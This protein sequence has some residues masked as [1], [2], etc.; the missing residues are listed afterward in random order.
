MN[1]SKLG[2]GSH[3][4]LA[5][6]LLNGPQRYPTDTRQEERLNWKVTKL[7]ELK[8]IVT[9]SIALTILL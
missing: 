2:N 4:Q 3:V 5:H 7:V 8:F 1:F 9:K 6:H